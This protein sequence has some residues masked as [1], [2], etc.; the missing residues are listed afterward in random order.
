M[1]ADLLLWLA[2]S[3]AEAAAPARDGARAVAEEKAGDRLIALA[4][5]SHGSLPM[6]L[7]ALPA[8]AQENLIR[9]PW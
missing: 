3:E 6:L 9:S 5:E 8:N 4:I 2:V 1:I 7:G